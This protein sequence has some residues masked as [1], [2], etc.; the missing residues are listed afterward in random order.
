MHWCTRLTFASYAALLAQPM[1]YPQAWAQTVTPAPAAEPLIPDW[2]WLAA[3]IVVVIVALWYF[4][5]TRRG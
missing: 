3:I 4:L 5:R 1:A 2:I